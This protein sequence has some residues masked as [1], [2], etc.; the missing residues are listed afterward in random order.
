[1]N[2]RPLVAITDYLAEA[3]PEKAVLDAFAEVVLL[4]TTDEADVVARAAD[5]SVLLV[6]HDIK[7]TERSIPHL[8]QCRGIV[9]CGVGFDNIDLHAA[10]RHGIVVCN[11]PDYGTEEVAD[12]ALMLLLAVARRLVATDQALRDGSWDVTTI[13]G[14]P[15]LRGKTLGL[16]GCGR[17]GTALALRA[18][19]LGLRVVF[20]DPY[21]PDGLDKALGIERCARLDDLLPQAQFLSLH[22]P[23]T[24]ET[25]HILNADTIGRLPRGAYVINT[26]R[27]ACIDLNALYAALETGHVAAAGLDVFER[28]PLTDERI[29]RHPR[30]ILSPHVAFYSVEGYIEMRTKGAQEARRIL[31][32]EPVR[33]PVNLHCLMNPRC[34]V[35]RPSPP[36]AP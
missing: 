14:A 19:A 33:N 35:P 22:C 10:G 12:H 15:R 16:I 5:A 30:V 2:Q 24:R 27:G 6:F 20:Y 9:R 21:K 36:E 32:G 13:F 23:L 3:G 7:L 25:R 17:I 31:L 18:K 26:A 11:V 4:Q 29:R 34:A 28:E 1:M 8:R